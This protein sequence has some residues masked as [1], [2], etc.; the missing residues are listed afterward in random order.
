MNDDLEPSVEQEASQDEGDKVENAPREETKIEKAVEKN[1]VDAPQIGASRSFIP[2]EP[3]VSSDD[4]K[5][6][7]PH[8]I[9]QSKRDGLIADKEGDSDEESKKPQTSRPS[10]FELVT[11]TGK[12]A[13]GLSN[14][15]SPEPTVSISS[16]D[17]EDEEEIRLDPIVHNEPK[18][19]QANDV[20]PTLEPI[21]ETDIDAETSKSDI[22]DKTETQDDLLDIPAFL[23]RQ[24]N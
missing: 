15:S 3:I 24:A 4:H 14:Q 13:I 10:L 5:D 9:K 23:R 11:R 2:P 8:E 19:T 22:G 17:I 21:I 6:S 16:S 20:T 1:L 18:E 7:K 12:A